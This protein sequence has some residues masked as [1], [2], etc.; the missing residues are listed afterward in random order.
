MNIL[1]KVKDNSKNE[2]LELCNDNSKKLVFVELGR[3]MFKDNEYILNKYFRNEEG[4]DCYYA[5]LLAFR[6]IK[7]VMT[8]YQLK[9]ILRKDFK[10][11]V[12]LIGY[13][14]NPEHYRFVQQYVQDE[15]EEDLFKYQDEDEV[16]DMRQ[17]D[18][19]D[20]DAV[21]QLSIIMDR[22]IKKRVVILFELE[23][24]PALLNR[25]LDCYCKGVSCKQC[26]KEMRAKLAS[27]NSL[28]NNKEVIEWIKTGPTDMSFDKEDYIETYQRVLRTLTDCKENLEEYRDCIHNEDDLFENEIIENNYIECD[29]IETLSYKAKIARNQGLYGEQ[30]VEEDDY[31]D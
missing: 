11:D 12:S 19:L 18:S 25:A 30:K 20:F 10:A 1:E 2:I 27:L 28:L 3:D 17:I 4:K 16:E 21:K 7:S 5:N 23:S 15:Y 13:R 29:S 8:P 9:N 6:E 22:A 14:Y 26:N 24:V 31:L